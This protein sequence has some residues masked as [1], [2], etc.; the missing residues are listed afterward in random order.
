M[1]VAFKRVYPVPYVTISPTDDSGPIVEGC[2]TEILEF[3]RDR[4]T[5]TL[6]VCGDE[7][8]IGGLWRAFWRG[9]S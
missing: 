3:P 1:K 6:H 4:F 8:Q 2:S 9:A 7:V 5:H